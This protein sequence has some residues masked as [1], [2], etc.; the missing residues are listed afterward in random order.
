MDVVRHLDRIILADA[1]TDGRCRVSRASAVVLET[2]GPRM[3][4]AVR[5]CPVAFTRERKV[6]RGCGH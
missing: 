4:L 1:A 2:I 6:S 3:G 5:P